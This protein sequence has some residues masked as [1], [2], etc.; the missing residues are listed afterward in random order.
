LSS[1]SPAFPGALL[2]LLAVS[3]FSTS[4]LL[5]RLSSPVPSLQVT[6]WRLAVAGGLV[7]LAAGLTGQL[8]AAPGFDVRRLGLYGLITAAHFWLYIASL[9]YTSVT[10]SLAIVYTAPVF[11]AAFSR[12]FLREPITRR[13]ALGIAV[14]VLGV[15]LLAGYDF[16]TNTRRLGGDL[17]ALGS[18]AAFGLYSVAGRSERKRYPLLVYAGSVYL[19]AALWLLPLAAAGFRAS[20]YTPGNAAAILALAVFPLALGH[21][22]YNAAL[23]RIHAARANVLSTLEVAGGAFLAWAVLGEAVPPEGAL[24]AAV[25]LAGVLLVML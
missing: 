24:G 14:V 6:F 10:N 25:T 23:R 3:L 20:A 18:A 13:Q 11:V 1:S 4:A 9:H 2:A 16:A 7:L 15:G 8:R 22:L 17:L 21:T 19:S 12:F 5:V